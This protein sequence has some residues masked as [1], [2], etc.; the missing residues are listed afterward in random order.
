MNPIDRRAAL[1]IAVCAALLPAAALAAPPMRVTLYKNP[2]CGC[3]EGYAD[4]LRQ[5]GFA[6]DVVPTN[7]LVTMARDKGVPEALDG[8]HIS[9][10]DGYVMIGHVP[11]DAVRKLLAERPNIIGISIPGMPTGLPG[12]PGPRPEPIAIYQIS[13]GDAAPKVFMMAS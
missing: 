7:D 6:V 8:C 9:M 1:F 5:N 4:Y 11:I 3:C 2:Q 12:M 13:R 10:I